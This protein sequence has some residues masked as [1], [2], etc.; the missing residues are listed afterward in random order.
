MDNVKAFG[1]KRVGESLVN[2]FIYLAS[3]TCV[4]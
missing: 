4:A 3:F 1:E 2:E